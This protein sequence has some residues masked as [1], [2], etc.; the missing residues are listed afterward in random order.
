MDFIYLLREN[1][2]KF[3]FMSFW[4]YDGCVGSKE[5]TMCLYVY[6]YP[7]SLYFFSPCFQNF[8]LPLRL[9]HLHKGLMTSLVS[10]SLF[11]LLPP[12]SFS[13]IIHPFYCI[14]RKICRTKIV[15]F[16]SHSWP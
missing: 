13:F 10:M 8:G 1:N 3:T 2:K 11:F 7:S 6:I 15:F 14:K 5:E 12:L 4:D 16:Q 9:R